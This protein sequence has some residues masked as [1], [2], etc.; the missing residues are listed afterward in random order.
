MNGTQASHVKPSHVITQN[1]RATLYRVLEGQWGPYIKSEGVTVK[2]ARFS[3]VQFTTEEDLVQLCG[4][5]QHIVMV[6]C[7]LLSST[8]KTPR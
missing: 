3:T 4:T 5:V 7:G 1:G 2:T 8:V 6:R